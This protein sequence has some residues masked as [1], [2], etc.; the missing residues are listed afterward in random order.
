MG[1]TARL[2]RFVLLLVGALLTAAGVL[3]LLTGFGVFGN[4]LRQR[5]VFDNVVGRFFSANGQWLWPAIALLMLLLAYLAYR[6][7]RGQL[8]PTSVREL[9]LEPT[10]DDGRTSL[11]GVAV[12]DA[13]A[14]EIETYRGVVGV[15]SRLTGTDTEPEL[16][17]RVELEDRADL[18]ALR[19]RIESQAIARARRALDAPQLPV[20]L[21]LVTTAKR[22]A[23]VS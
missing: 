6:W 14:G 17:L 23:R 8:R 5:P 16:R 3:A 4:A 13:I 11:A 9:E 22:G 7:L 2:D 18:A 1:T 21:D 10:S 19:T 15:R 12:T 20:R